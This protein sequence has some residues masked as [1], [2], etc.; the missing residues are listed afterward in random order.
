MC[1]NTQVLASP[2]KTQVHI[3]CVCVP[4]SWSTS[5][6]QPRNKST[7]VKQRYDVTFS[8][9]GLISVLRKDVKIYESYAR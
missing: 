4:P 7:F 9:T 2:L 6:K 8:C 1:S 5:I 3:L